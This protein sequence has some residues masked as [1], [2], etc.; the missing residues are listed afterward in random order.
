MGR[1]TIIV[2][3]MDGSRGTGQGIPMAPQLPDQ[4]DAWLSACP[5]L[6]RSPLV[7]MKEAGLLALRNSYAE[8]AR[9]KAAL[10]ERTGLFGLAGVWGGPQLVN[11][12]F[13]A[14]NATD[15]QRAEWL[16]RPAS[17]AISEPGVGAHP[18]HLRTRAEPNEDGFRIT[19]EKAW[20]SNAAFAEVI[21]IFAITS[22][23]PDGRKRYSAFL[24]PRDT[25][26]L[27]VRD[28]PGFHAL[29]PSR[30]STVTLDGCHVPTTGLLGEPGTAY[31]RMALPFRDTE[32][33]VGGYA[34]TG[35]FRFLLDRFRRNHIRSDDT[36]LALGAL[37]ALTAVLTDA[38]DAVVT[39]LDSE[40]LGA[41]TPSLI[42]TR[43]LATEML[44]RAQA[45]RREHVPG[46]ETGADTVLKDI[47][48][49]LSI[50]RG[51]RLARQMRLADETSPR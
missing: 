1:S 47:E 36:A 44:A 48:T 2:R 46:E 23:D 24:V 29:A 40:R 37:A 34:L 7:G 35:A 21:I 45:F 11:R 31:E 41:A 8:I 50:A 20:A 13:I 33:A 51:P 43:V 19:G 22:Q 26:G 10:V 39:A 6:V 4:I 16:G 5:D 17:V 32:D 9:T 3:G 28:M 42:G 14:P 12:F 38:A 25:P 30:H 18:K 15:A 49:M 27:S